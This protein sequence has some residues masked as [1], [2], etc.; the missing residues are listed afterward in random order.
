MKAH[1]Y[2]IPGARPLSLNVDRAR[3]V[4]TGWERIRAFLPILVER[5]ARGELGL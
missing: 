1:S 4:W 3:S 2:A 5:A